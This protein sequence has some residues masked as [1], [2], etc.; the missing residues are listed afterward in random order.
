MATVS[1]RTIDHLE[2]IWNDLIVPVC[3]DHS[4]VT[5]H[6]LGAVGDNMPILELLL[7]ESN[8]VFVFSQ[9]LLR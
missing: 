9:R 1:L 7:E 3:E 5:T 8:G 2:G 4:Q 6:R